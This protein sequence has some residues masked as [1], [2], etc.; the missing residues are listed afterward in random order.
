VGLERH[1]FCIEDPFELSHDLSRTVHAD[2]CDKLRHEFR[3]AWDVLRHAASTQQALQELFLEAPAPPAPPAG[4]GQQQQQQQQSGTPTAWAAAAAA[5][6]GQLGT[7]AAG[8]NMGGA[9]EAVLD[10]LGLGAASFGNG[11]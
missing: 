1:L 7:L 6:D 11:V 8:D 3:R 10:A 9:G 5:G 4:A 2:G